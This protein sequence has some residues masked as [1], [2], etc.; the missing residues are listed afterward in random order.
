MGSR[1]VSYRK[2]DLRLAREVAK[3][4]DRIEV[5]RPD[6]TTITLIA[7]KAG[8]ARVVPNGGGTG[9]E[10]NPWD[11]VLTDATKQERAS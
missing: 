10:E 1:K 7:G 5:K 3:E 9:E 6:G 11:G 8:E 4:G 2:R